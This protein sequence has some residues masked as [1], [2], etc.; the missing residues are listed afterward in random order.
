MGTPAKTARFAQLVKEAGEPELVTLWTAPEAN[1]EFMRAVEQNRVATVIQRN[2]GVKKDFGLIGFFSRPHAAFLVFPKALPYPPETRI[3]GIHYEKISA[4]EPKGPLHR[5]G[6]S[7][8]RPANTAGG[9]TKGEKKPNVQRFTVKVDLAARYETEL[10]VEAAS[11]AEATRRAK[12]A[13]EGLVFEVGKAAVTRRV[14]KPKR[15]K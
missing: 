7:P 9:P 4:A 10:A 13:A 3:T 15:L 6:A 8:K 11:A 5:P 2:V 14:W 1:A 12:A